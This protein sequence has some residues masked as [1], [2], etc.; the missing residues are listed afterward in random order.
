MGINS[1]LKGLSQ[2]YGVHISR[3]IESV[4]DLAH[5]IPWPQ[6]FFFIFICY[7]G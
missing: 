7:S 5:I 4:E 3:R 2:G 1:G 6:R